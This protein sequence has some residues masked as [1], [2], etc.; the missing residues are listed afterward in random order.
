[1]EGQA[2]EARGALLAHHPSRPVRHFQVRP[3]TLICVS[4]TPSLTLARR[5]S[6][7]LRSSSLFAPLRSLC[8]IGRISPELLGLGAPC[9]RLHPRR[10]GSCPSPLNVSC[11]R[12][13]G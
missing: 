6:P 9:I 1:V 3:S 4:V 13:G 10:I 12:M 11:D 5:M 2:Q 7:P 8:P